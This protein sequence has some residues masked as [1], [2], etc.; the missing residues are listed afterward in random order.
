MLLSLSACAGKVTDY[1]NATITGKVTAIS[2]SSVTMQLGTLTEA[3]GGTGQTP[4]DAPSGGSADN[5]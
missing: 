5:T 1:S 3:A 4:P 2:G